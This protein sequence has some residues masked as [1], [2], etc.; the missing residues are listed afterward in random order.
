[1]GLWPL[2]ITP[3]SGGGL[4]EP[5]P[6]IEDLA[7][8][9]DQE[10]AAAIGPDGS[11]LFLCLPRFDSQPAFSRLVDQLGGW[12]RV[13]PLDVRVPASRRYV[14][15]TN[16]LETTWQTDTGWIV[17]EQF[18]AF[19]PWHH[20]EE[21]S[22]TF[23]TVPRYYDAQ[24]VLVTRVRC[25]AGYVELVAECQPRPDF[26]AK[27]VKWRYAGPGYQQ[28]VAE[29]DGEPPLIFVADPSMRWGFEGSRAV[30]RRP[31][32]KGEEVFV[33]LAWTQHELPR[34]VADATQMFDY[35]VE[36]WRSLLEQGTFPDVPEKEY[37]QRA[38]LTLLGLIYTATGAI[39]AAPTTSLPENHFTP[40]QVTPNSRTYDYRFSW[41]R[42]S[43]LILWALETLG[44]HADASSFVQYILA[45]VHEGDLPVLGAIGEEQA[46]LTEREVEHATGY[47]WTQPVRTGNGAW[48]HNQ[49][50]RWGAVLATIY[51]AVRR[52]PDRLDQSTWMR[53]I[54][55]VTTAASKWRDPDRGIWE[56]RG[57]QQHFVSSKIMCWLAMQTGARLAVLRGDEELRQQWQDVAE[58]IRADVLQNGVD[59]RPALV[60]A[61]GS[62]GVDASNLLAILVGFLEPDDPI[63]LATIDAIR[64]ELLKDGLVYRYNAERTDDGSDTDEQSF[65]ICT[66]WLISALALSG[67]Q[68]SAE[69]MLRHML[70]LASPLKLWSEEV[71]PE[72]GRHYGNTPLGLS[73]VGLIMAITL[74]VRGR[75]GH[76]EPPTPAV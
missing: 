49:H 36:V 48:N 56:V 29:S 38:A 61:Y 45:R 34:T 19:G 9:Y 68:Q 71:D 50:D 20:T 6:R 59:E 66:W 73:A 12:M 76:I 64:G 54:E 37:L 24:H 44:F 53:V 72:T 2:E 25:I 74:V 69:E 51:A 41:F 31:L 32:Q 52:N 57:P 62:E 22:E 28:V 46:D 67:Q 21:R 16:V 30:A 10:T 11:V 17:V 15:G 65:V 18:L 26:G 63:A 5:F 7:F 39:V 27:D 58:E 35:T 60:Q 75:Q 43:W 14:P 3:P 23:L 4:R 42:D 55:L 70:T 33:A 13:A 1:M 47:Y 8:L 40:G